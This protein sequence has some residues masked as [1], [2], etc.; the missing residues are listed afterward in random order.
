MTSIMNVT[1][2]SATII[3]PQKGT[4]TIN[5]ATIVSSLRDESP[6]STFKNTCF[7]KRI[8]VSN[9]M[10]TK[11]EKQKQATSEKTKNKQQAK[12]K[13][14]Q[15]ATTKRRK[16]TKSQIYNNNNE[17]ARENKQRI[18]SKTSKNRIYSNKNARE[19]EPRVP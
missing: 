18:L 1:N 4:I 7:I 15:Q 2:N 11:E 3:Y 9:F 17:N 19:I 13:N 8:N 14:K 12:T 6:I 16:T 10:R 5:S